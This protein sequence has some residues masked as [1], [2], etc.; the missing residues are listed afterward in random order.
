MSNHKTSLMSRL[1]G[2]AAPPT[3]QSA[4]P[5]T[6]NI[7]PHA[8]DEVIVFIVAG[9]HSGDLLGAGLMRELS[10]TLKGQVRFI[11]V[12]GE[13]MEA[14]GLTSLFAL[15]D[16]AVMGPVA[17]LRALPRLTNRVY[18]TVAAGVAANPDI[19]VII[20]SPEFTHRVGKRLRRK[21][22]VTPIINYVCPSVWAWRP[23]RAKYMATFIDHVLALLPFEPAAL[24]RLKGPP[25]TYIGHPLSERQAWIQSIDLNSWRARFQLDPT[26]VPLVVLP[27]SRYSEIENLMPVFRETLLKL[28]ADGH[29]LELLMPTVPHLSQRIEALSSDWPMPKHYITEAEAK[30]AA[31]RLA[32]AALAASGTVTL[33]LGVAGTPMVVTYLVDGLAVHLRP[34]L[35]VESVVLANLVLEENAFPE[36]LQEACNAEQ[37]STALASLI[38]DTPQRDAQ[39]DA[40]RRL[41]QKMRPPP[42]TPSERAAAVVMQFVSGAR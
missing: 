30:F 21:L 34:L 15:A 26:R 8:R 39:L 35:K 36:L 33:E 1:R 6:T 23:G 3:P 11:G 2:Q 14:Q 17:I 18:R 40:L 24:D 12:G 20:D 13:A 25:A 28:E 16:I 42:V 31:F 41:G 5:K 38:D 10:K 7:H 4:K 29:Q 9:E 19:I 22:P 27:G 37:L 32:R